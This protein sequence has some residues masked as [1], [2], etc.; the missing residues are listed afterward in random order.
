[1]NEQITMDDILEDKPAEAPTETPAAE[2]PAAPPTETAPVERPTSRR[3]VHRDKEQLAQ[4]RVRDPETGQFA[5]KPEEAKAEEKPKE[6]PKESP[7]A[8]VVKH[9]APQQEMTDKE[10]AFLR[11]AEEERRK[12]Q[13]LERELQ[14]ARSKAP[15]T[16]EP[17]KTFWDDPEGWMS[18]HQEQ[19][20]QERLKERLGVAEMLARSKYTDFDEKVATFTDMA[21]TTP[22]LIQA[23][24]ASPD[25]A[26]YAYRAGKN[27]M[28]LRE[29]GSIDGLK[30]K[31]EKEAYA[32]ARA[33]MKKEL[34]EKSAALAKERAALPPSLSEARST[35]VNK[36][37]WSGPPSMEDILGRK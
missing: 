22:G 16:T 11:A 13:A 37:V 15:A 2:A 8:E 36:P 14:E 18:R 28:E 12:R 24:L 23:W 6:E 21:K 31:I 9:T 20:R 4:G 32:K 19:Q 34:E 35:G 33:D 25:P 27:H 7:K 30:A 26:E 3:M 10:K 1:M 5:P 29:A 17:A